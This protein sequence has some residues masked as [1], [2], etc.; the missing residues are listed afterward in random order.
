MESET[1]VVAPATEEPNLLLR[2]RN[3]WE[4][5]SL[6]QYIFFFGKAVR[7]ED[8][9][10]EVSLTHLSFQRYDERIFIAHLRNWLLTDNAGV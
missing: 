8:I 4:F 5:A 1:S 7:V 9:E 2:I 3:M 6:M 10:V